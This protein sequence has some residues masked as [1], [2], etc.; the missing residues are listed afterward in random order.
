MKEDNII[1]RVSKL[2]MEFKYTEDELERLLTLV[3][4]QGVID[5]KLTSVKDLLDYRI[6]N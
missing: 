1:T 6:K 2:I 5:Q 3:Y 4:K